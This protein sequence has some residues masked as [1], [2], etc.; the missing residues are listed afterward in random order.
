MI[1]K[2]D[3][4]K[5][6]DL[7][8]RSQNLSSETLS[9]KRINKVLI[10]RK[11]IEKRICAM[12]EK[13]CA[14]YSHI[15]LLTVLVVLKGGVIFASD[16]VREIYRHGGPD[17]NVE[18]LKVSAYGKEIKR[19]KETGRSIEIE[20]EPNNPEGKDILLVEDLVDQ[21]FTVSYLEKYI[22]KL[23]TNSLKICILL[24]KKLNNPSDSVLKIKKELKCNYTG[25]NIPDVWVAG[26]GMDFEENLRNLP[27]IVEVDENY[28][29]KNLK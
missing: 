8:C 4:R 18:F 14:D 16:L 27:F 6:V 13:I 19:E 26:Y 5:T 7:C 9:D 12:A 20:L 3:F 22:N 10:P 15:Q 2:I 25:F 11:Y 1:K 29:N 23:N 24:D 21:G 17:I 28:Y